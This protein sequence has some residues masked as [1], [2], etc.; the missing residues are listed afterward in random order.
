MVPPNFA[1]DW[2]IVSKVISLSLSP[3]TII[4]YHK[5]NVPLSAYWPEHSFVKRSE[6]TNTTDIEKTGRTMDIT[7]VPDENG[8]PIQGRGV[9]TYDWY[10]PKR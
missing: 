3:E 1:D 8:Q 7:S 2:V 10:T 5:R 9:T 6:L 4:D